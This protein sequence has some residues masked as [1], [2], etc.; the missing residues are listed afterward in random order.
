MKIL[1]S[2]KTVQKFILQ[3]KKKGKSIGFVPTMGALH[4]GHLSLVRR[5]RN[6]NDLTVTSIFV[7]PKQFGPREDFK[8]YPR[9]GE[10][11]K[12]LLQKNKVDILFYPSVEEIYPRGYRT[13]VE[14]EGLD[15]VLCGRIR[16]RHFKGVTTVVAKL[17]NVV[18]P[19][20]LYLG[21][22]DAQQ[23][24]ILKKM[25]QDLGFPI[26]VQ[27]CPTVREKDGLAMSS[28]NVYLS[29]SDRQQVPVLYQ[30]LHD[31]KRLIRRGE[32]RASKI[33]QSIRHMIHQHTQGAINYIECVSAENLAPLKV[34]KGNV[35]I[36]VSVTFGKTKLIDNISV[37]A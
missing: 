9:D 13:Y 16:P 17:L 15:R 19:D 12:F 6:A 20:T 14:V 25:I 2:V 7:N 37:H 26:S 31:A 33:T 28:R 32:R 1:R 27:I 23:V 10:K 5:C 8:R 4:E 21:A 36:A 30:S 34:L 29:D 35:L 24:V 11:D 3:A 22:K 18:L